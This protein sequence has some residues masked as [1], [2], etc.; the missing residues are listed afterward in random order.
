[1][2]ADFAAVSKFFSV[3]MPKVKKNN[4][5]AYKK[6]YSEVAVGEALRAIEG[7]MSKKAASKM[8]G[9]PRTTLI[10]RLSDK[11]RKIDPGPSP[12][13]TAAEEATLVEWIICN[14]KKGFPRRKEDVQESV[15]QFLDQ[16][17]RPN[18]FRDN[19]PGDGWFKAFLRRHPII[20]SRTSEAVTK[21]S[22]NVSENDLRK[23]FTNIESYLREEGYLEI[24][25]DLS[26]VFNGDETC[27]LL[28][29]KGNKVLAPKGTRNVY[30]IDIGQAK[31]SLTA[32]FTFGANGD[33]IPPMIIYPNK[34][35]FAEIAKSLPD[36]WGYGLSDND[37]MKAECF[38]EY[39]ANILHPYLKSK[40]TL[41]PIIYFVD[42]HA[43]HLT[44]QLSQ[45]CSD[46]GIILIY[47]YP[48]STRILQPAD[49]AAFK[50]VKNAWKRGVLEWRRSHPTEALTKD[51][52]APILKLT[53][54]KCLTK[55][56]IRNG[57]RACGLFPWNPNA[58]DYSKCLGNDGTTKVADRVVTNNDKT[59]KVNKTLDLNTLKQII[60][61]DILR[62]TATG[63][64]DTKNKYFKCLSNIVKE[65]TEENAL[66][67]EEQTID[68]MNMEINAETE[69]VDHKL[70]HDIDHNFEETQGV[71]SE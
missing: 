18:P 51:R 27:F 17:P 61:N 49:V 33:I 26:R 46:L 38:Y 55:D 4:C 52:F 2:A 22:A 11:F 9:I 62:E 54:D 63:K 40:G 68:E 60:D 23:W 41:F 42:G 36:D 6:I 69:W 37:W 30:E 58:I 56:T 67:Q 21:A 44:Y 19:I 39:V 24:L 48:N 16:N 31:S 8:F 14:Q 13:L 50:P 12:V 3:A 20:T 1:L 57:F 28:C 32:M 66:L 45:L 65:L 59:G 29:P 10:F 35:R 64:S 5:E 53:I 25:T 7:G 15:K 47:L 43:T 70:I 34:R 71:I